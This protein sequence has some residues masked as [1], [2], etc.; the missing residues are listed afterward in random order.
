M[1]FVRF[2]V[3]ASLEEEVGSTPFGSNILIWK[4]QRNVGLNEPSA[5][6]G[7]YFVIGSQSFASNTKDQTLACCTR[8]KGCR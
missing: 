4:G 7:S 2:E 1:H 6:I 3:E 5:S 8:D